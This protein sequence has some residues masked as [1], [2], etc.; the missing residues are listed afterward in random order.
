MTYTAEIE[1]M[2]MEVNEL[3]NQGSYTE[4]KERLSDLLEQEPGYGR[5]HNHMAWL[6]ETQLKDSAKAAYHYRLALKFAP[7]Y[8]PVYLNY[9]WFLFDQSQ[10]KAHR[11]LI[12]EAMTVNGIN[13]PALLNELGRSEEVAGNFRAAAKH[14]KHAIA[15]SLNTD[16]IEVFKHNIKRVL[17]KLSLLDRVILWLSANS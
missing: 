12:A 13:K 16:E 15:K 6:Y 3:M 17:G 10:M 11:A 14:Y 7:D 8:L 9:I 5:A 2:F 1:S 4:A